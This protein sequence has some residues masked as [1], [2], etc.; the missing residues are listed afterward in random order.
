MLFDLMTSLLG[1]LF[2]KDPHLDGKL[3]LSWKC[4]SMSRIAVCVFWSPTLLK[5]R[6]AWSFV[7]PQVCCCTLSSARSSFSSLCCSKNLF[8]FISLL[9]RG[10]AL[11]NGFIF[12]PCASTH[13]K[14][15]KI[16]KNKNSN[17]N[18]SH[19]KKSQNPADL[20]GRF[21]CLRFCEYTVLKTE[22][23]SKLAE[24]LRKNIVEWMA[25]EERIRP[26]ST[27]NKGQWMFSLARQTL[28]RCPL[29]SS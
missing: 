26:L 15:S 17:L 16:S 2:R 4:S 3:S 12:C 18:F 28:V 14:N 27:H 10:F 7:L 13:N 23:F 20:G 21:V 11:V 8:I 1:M 19:R 6:S 29:L 22:M 25:R 5:C 9:W 24:I